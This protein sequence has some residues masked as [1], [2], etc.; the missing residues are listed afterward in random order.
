MTARTDARLRV[1]GV[2]L[3]RTGT[4][5]LRVGLQSLLGAPCYGM[6][7]LQDRLD[8]HLPLWMRALR[9]E[10]DLVEAILD[11]YPAVVGWPTSTFWPELLQ[12][13]PDAL[14]VLS[15][16]GDSARWWR[17]IDA[18]IFTSM[19]GEAAQAD[20]FLALLRRR[21]GFGAEWAAEQAARATYERHFAQIVES[22]PAERL[23]VWQPE[24]GWA[25]LCRALGLDVP[26]TDFFHVNSTTDYRAATGLPELVS[27][28]SD[29]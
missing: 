29:A 15:H 9:G 13:H 19:R 21:A 11:G 17:S 24:D 8:D 16:R 22:T 27:N 2:G 10:S 25:P 18:T 1:I 14:F 5:S 23:V 12:R 7:V 26:G 4:S 6:R 20:E 3:P 28:P